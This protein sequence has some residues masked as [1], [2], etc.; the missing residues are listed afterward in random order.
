MP[1]G[2]HMEAGSGALSGVWFSEPKPALTKAQYET[3]KSNTGTSSSDFDRCFIIY[4]L[5]TWYKPL[6]SYEIFINL[7]IF[8]HCVSANL[9]AF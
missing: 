1:V 4:N 7:I 5:Q 8:H 6:V 2:S 9:G 3:C